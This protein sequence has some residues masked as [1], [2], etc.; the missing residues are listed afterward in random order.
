MT[1]ITDFQD[2]IDNHMSQVGADV[3]IADGLGNTITLLGVTLSD[4][5]AVD[6]V[7]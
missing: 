4:L 7:F 1:E 5:D 6:F 3:V 2:L